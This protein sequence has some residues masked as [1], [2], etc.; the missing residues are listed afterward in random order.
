MLLDSSG[1]VIYLFTNGGQYLGLLGKSGRGPG[2][3]SAAEDRIVSSM[4]SSL[5]PKCGKPPAL[6]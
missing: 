4:L 1:P 2:Q 6:L 5:V 3:S